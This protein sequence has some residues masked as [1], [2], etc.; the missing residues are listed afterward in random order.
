MSRTCKF[1][2]LRPSLGT[3][4]KPDSKFNIEHWAVTW[5]RYMTWQWWL[6]WFFQSTMTM[7]I[8]IDLEEQ[9]KPG[10][11]EAIAIDPITHCRHLLVLLTIILAQ[12]TQVFHQVLSRPSNSGPGNSNSGRFTTLQLHPG[13]SQAFPVPDSHPRCNPWSKLFS[14]LLSLLHLSV[15]PSLTLLRS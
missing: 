12:V 14:V 3:W 10:Q 6:W 2:Y 9:L 1:M 8:D 5:S 4:M 13:R 7:E 11:L 15:Y